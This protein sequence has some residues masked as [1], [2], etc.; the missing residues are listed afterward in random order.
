M[1]R[2]EEQKK[3]AFS[4]YFDT[5]CRWHVGSRLREYYEPRAADGNHAGVFAEQRSHV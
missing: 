4:K 3:Y 2:S 5:F 1:G